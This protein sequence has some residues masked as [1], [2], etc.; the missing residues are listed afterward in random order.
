MPKRDYYEIL[1]VSRDAGEIEI[2]KAYKSMA[3]KYHPD[4]NPN[5]ALAEEKFKEAS[6]AFQVLVDPEKRRIYDVY[7]H[8]GLS[9]SGFRGIDGID[10]IFGSSFFGDLFKDLFGFGF[11]FGGFGGRRS[12]SDYGVAKGRDIQ[13][14]MSITLEEAFGGVKREVELRF[15]ETCSSCSGTGA[16]DG[17]AFE[18]CPTC[19]GKGQVVHSRGAFILTTTCGSCGGT[20]RHIVRK[21]DACGGEGRMKVDNT[22]EVKIPEGIENEQIIRVAGK[23]EPGP[24]GGP[25][26]DLYI[27]VYVDRHETYQRSGTELIRQI[28]VTYPEA[29][30]GKKFEMETLD[31]PA[32]VKIPPGTQPG[33]EIVIRGK[34]MPALHGRGRGNLHLIATLVVPKKISRKQKK[35][36]EELDREENS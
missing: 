28:Y 26:G 6:E 33:E 21:C 12:S 10:D 7:G 14:K 4:R 24:G 34:G 29:V 8:E 15:S 36:I 1:G 19:Q 13:K 5:D 32:R 9:G 35:L 11:G 31:G 27:V 25:N 16:E 18:S 20:G 23:G 17:E 3:L 22:I 30:L 2:K